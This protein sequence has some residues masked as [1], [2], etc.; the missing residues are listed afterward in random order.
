MDCKEAKWPE[1]KYLQL[2]Q[3]A[4]Q[5][6]ALDAGSAEALVQLLQHADLACQVTLAP[7]PAQICAT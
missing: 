5:R 2:S 7:L 3:D 4:L 6:K 1:C